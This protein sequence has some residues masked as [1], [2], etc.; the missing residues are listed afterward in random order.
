[1]ISFEEIFHHL[2]PKPRGQ[3]GTNLNRIERSD[4]LLHLRHSDV[5]VMQLAGHLLVVSTEMRL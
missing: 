1:M 5:V 2:C 4:W 3:L